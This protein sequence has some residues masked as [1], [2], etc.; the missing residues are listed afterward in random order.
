MRVRAKNKD[1]LIFLIVVWQYGML[2]LHWTAQV[3]EGLNRI[4]ENSN[5]CR[6]KSN[7]LTEKINITVYRGWTK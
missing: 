4:K 5:Y 2:R 1:T 6:K 7:Q 3:I